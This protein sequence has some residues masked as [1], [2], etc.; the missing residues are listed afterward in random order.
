MAKKQKNQVPEPGWINYAWWIVPVLAIILYIPSFQ[1]GFTL[2]DVPIIEENSYVKS[3]GKIPDIWTSHYWAGKLDA[4]DTGL[5]RPLTLTTYTLYVVQGEHPAAFHILIIL[6]HALTCFVLMKFVHL[7]FKDMLLAGVSG[8]LFAIHPLHTEA[9]AGIVGRAEILS[10]LFILLA[11]IAYHHWRKS[12]RWIW[13]GALM[14]STFGAITSKEHGFM[15]PAILV[16][17]NSGR[18]DLVFHG[19]KRA[20][21]WHWQVQPL[22]PASCGYTEVPLLAPRFLTNCGQ[23]SMPRPAWPRLSASQPNMYGC[24]SFH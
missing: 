17:R 20:N 24:T 4:S 11:G 3:L 18:D 16:L 14:V 23:A 15:I 10:S 6:L 2:D 7:V 13:M 5:Y 21:G 12:S 22:Q 8:L 19:Q 1:A 9:V